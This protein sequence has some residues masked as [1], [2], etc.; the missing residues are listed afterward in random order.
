MVELP[1]LELV[2]C[3]LFEQEKSHLTQIN[4]YHA[5]V[6]VS[7]TAVSY[8][9]EV[10][11]T[12]QISLNPTI[13]FIAVGQ[14][15]AHVFNQFWQKNYPTPPNL[16][17]PSDLH[18][19]ENN[20]GLLQL[21]YIQNL[22][23][24]DT[25]LLLKGKEGRELL[26]NTLLEKGVTVDSVEFYQRVFPANSRQIFQEFCQS[27]HFLTQKIVLISSL[28]AWENWQILIQSN[29][30]PSEFAYIVLQQR[31]ANRMLHAYQ[32]RLSIKVIDDLQPITIFNALL[33]K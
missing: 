16:I 17:T 27:K 23:I 32:T 31:I 3:Q 7:E 24:G 10:I 25:V 8:F 5:L 4:S 30:T 14:K 21:P 26:T 2:A 12:H 11:Q 19:P 18:L 1:L 13:S 20:E 15:T 29:A 6:F 28:T 33:D 9:F 22:K